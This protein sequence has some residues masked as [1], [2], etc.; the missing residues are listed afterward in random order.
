[1]LTYNLVRLCI[2]THALQIWSHS[3]PDT[4]FPASKFADLRMIAIEGERI[5]SVFRGIAINDIL[6]RLSGQVDTKTGKILTI[7]VISGKNLRCLTL[8]S[9][10]RVS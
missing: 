3:L 4:I 8:T 10:F 5:R 6:L 7:L 9:I 2:G 1:M